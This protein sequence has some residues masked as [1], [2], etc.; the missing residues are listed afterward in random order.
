MTQNARRAA[1]DY[2]DLNRLLEGADT[3]LGRGDR[4]EANEALKQASVKVAS[5]WGVVGGAE[6]PE[7]ARSLMSLTSEVQRSIAHPEED[8]LED[9][10]MNLRELRRRFALEARS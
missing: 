1:T 5:M 3:S 2:G 10:Q 6:L 8:G 4:R 9:L 7:S